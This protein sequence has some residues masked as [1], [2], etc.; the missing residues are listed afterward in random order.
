MS[1]ILFLVPRMNIGGAETYVYTV[2]KELHRRGEHE[3]FVASAGGAL[4]DELE[5]MG[6]KTFFIPVRFS[7]RFCKNIAIFML[8]K[9]IKKYNIDVV[10]A[11]SG[12]AGCIVAELKKSIDIPVVYTAHGIFGNIER[13]Y[14]IDTVDRIICVSNF[15]KQRAIKQNFSENKLLTR[16]CGVDVERFKPDMSK[17]IELRRMY[18]IEES[19]LV[20]ATV[21]RIKDLEHKGHG[22]LLEMFEKYASDKDWKLIVVGKGSGLIQFK[23]RIKKA[24]LDNKIICLG[25]RTDVENILNMA[26]I[27][28]SPTRFETFGLAIAEGMAME[29]PGVAYE[30]GGTSE[31]INDGVSGFLVEFKNVQNLYE[32]INCLDTNRKLLEDMSRQAR[33]WVEENF[34][35]KQMVDG[36]EE[37]YSDVLA[38]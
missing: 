12:D 8:R 26:D 27:Y 11:N 18:G 24:G 19:T 6:I 34:T 23:Y 28:V 30:I 3:V 17:R 38:K 16:Y 5:K 32:K 7:R 35:I 29:K 22:A 13:E 9:I 33:I 14:V 10:H 20:L 2:A 25:H 21:S 36:L 1:R 37:I 4:S 31:V 15:V